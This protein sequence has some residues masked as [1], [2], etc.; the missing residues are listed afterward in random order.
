MGYYARDTNN[1]IYQGFATVR[2]FENECVGCPPELGCLGDVCS[3]RNVEHFYCDECGIEDTLY[4]INDK[5]LC[6]L[7]VL[8]ELKIIEGSECF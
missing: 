1:Y 4:E 7:C 6:G 8:G 5:E 2:K 3:N